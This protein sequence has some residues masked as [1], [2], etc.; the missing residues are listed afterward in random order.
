MYRSG[1]YPS[2]YMSTNTGACSVLFFKSNFLYVDSSSA[3]H[4]VYGKISFPVP[5]PFRKLTE[6]LGL[7]KEQRLRKCLPEVELS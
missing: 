5:M 4:M 7:I 6:R 3:G 1:N 2:V